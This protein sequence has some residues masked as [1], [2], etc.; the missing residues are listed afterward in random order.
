M[1]SFVYPNGTVEDHERK[2]RESLSKLQ[3]AGYRANEKKT[4]IFEGEL[5]WLDYYIYHKGVKPVTYK[6][7]EN[8]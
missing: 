1:T 4:E 8:V 6:Q 5:T 7:D 3:D 2:L